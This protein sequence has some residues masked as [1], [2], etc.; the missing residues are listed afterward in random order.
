MTVKGKLIRLHFISRLLSGSRLKNI[1]EVRSSCQEKNFF[2]HAVIASCTTRTRG[3]VL[4]FASGK[5]KP[6]L[7]LSTCLY[8]SLYLGEL[9]CSLCDN[10]EVGTSCLMLHI[11]LSLWRLEHFGREPEMWSPI[12]NSTTKA[13][14][15]SNL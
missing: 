4:L 7:R 9:Y 12:V 14:C 13:R 3:C 1:K 6:A 11:S 2:T 5:V 10:A 8:H 15:V